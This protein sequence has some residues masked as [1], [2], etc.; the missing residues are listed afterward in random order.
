[1]LTPRE[2]SYMMREEK[3]SYL[4][5][6]FLHYPYF[7]DSLREANKPCASE[8]EG[9][10]RHMNMIIMEQYEYMLRFLARAGR[11]KDPA[12]SHFAKTTYR[13][14]LNAGTAILQ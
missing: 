10:K 8:S 6:V 14:V 3:F 4:F 1:M 13:A 11:D 9:M 12:V 2:F 5:Q 7:I